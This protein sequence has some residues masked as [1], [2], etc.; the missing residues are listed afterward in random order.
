MTTVKSHSK[1]TP[2]QL[3]LK[4]VGL[5]YTPE[6][7]QDKAGKATVDVPTRLFPTL[8]TKKSI[9][10]VHQE[11][12]TANDF[13][14]RAK[15]VA[16]LAVKERP[17]PQTSKTITPIL[18]IDIGEIPQRAKMQFSGSETTLALP[19]VRSDS[20]RNLDEEFITVPLTEFVQINCPHIARPYFVKP[21]VL[22]SWPI[23]EA[24]GYSGWFTKKIKRDL[25]WERFYSSV[26]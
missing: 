3:F 7:T 21:L 26:L 22:P 25:E 4:A 20:G 12:Q 9:T 16:G 2:S 14:R 13:E 10:S 1:P 8:K 15:E 19:R 18:D 5:A 17:T 6:L 24:A 11:Q 23:Q